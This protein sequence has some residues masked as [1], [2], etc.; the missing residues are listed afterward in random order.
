MEAAADALER[1]RET[2]VGY[3]QNAERYRLAYMKRT[4][5]DPATGAKVKNKTAKAERMKNIQ[6]GYCKAMGH[7]RRICEA[8]KA[9]YR[10]YLVETRQV[11]EDLA[12]R[13]RES[14]IGAGS[15]VAFKAPG[16]DSAGDW[17]SHTQLNYIKGYRW[18]TCDS[19]SQSLPVEYVS[20]KNIPRMSDPY[21]VKS[22]NFDALVEKM[23]AQDTTSVASLAGSC[24]APEGWTDG[25]RTLKEAFPTQGSKC[26]KE[27]QYQYSWPS[28]SRKEII[29][30]LGLQEY[31]RLER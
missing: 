5:I 19:H 26:E 28:D 24:A 1:N 30:R 6:C 9:D 11:R 31:Y 7:T 8:V 21:H 29:Q 18:E 14:G 27:R 13:V 17:G 15:M 22:I 16:Y 4:K 25:G 10:V 23:K 12:T 20:H 2:A 3:T